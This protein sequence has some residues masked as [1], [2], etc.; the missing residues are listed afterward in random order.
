MV[1]L[2]EFYDTFAKKSDEKYKKTQNCER[3]THIKGTTHVGLNDSVM[4]DECCVSRGG[5]LAGCTKEPIT[6]S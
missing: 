3:A 6:K 2:N 4:Y 1:I 5:W